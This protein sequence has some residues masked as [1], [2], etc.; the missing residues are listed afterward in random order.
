MCYSLLSSDERPA[1]IRKLVL[2]TP[3]RDSEKLTELLDQLQ[4]EVQRDAS[5]AAPS[6]LM[7]QHE[8]APSPHAS[9]MAAL[10]P[11][12]NAHRHHQLSN[13]TPTSSAGGSAS[14]AL[15]MGAH[16]LHHSASSDAV[17]A[18]DGSHA[19]QMTLDEYFTKEFLTQYY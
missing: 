15:L 8:P 2:N 11:N 5:R 9:F 14:S 13:S 16:P 7:P 18:N 4:Y 10:R 3:S 1:K 6:S 19:S 17:N 12:A